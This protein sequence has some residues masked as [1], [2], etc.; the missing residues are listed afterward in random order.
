[1]AEVE[2]WG[3]TLGAHV[4]VDVRVDG[5]RP[6]KDARHAQL[7]DWLAGMLRKHGW[8]VLVEHS[9]NHFGDRGRIDVLAFHLIGRVLLVV[10]VKTRTDDAGDILG[11][12]DVKRR[13]A[14]ILARQ[15]QWPATSTV[16]MLLVLEHRTNR[17]RIADHA[18]IFAGFTLR[19]R[20]A[21]AWIRRPGAPEPSA[22]LLFAGGR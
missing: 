5:E 21:S 19:G 7:Q 20:A 6:M 14:P 22:I 16:P 12:L 2:R 3:V 11:R 10:E 9:F 8:S 13:V 17:R 15:Q 18:A 1:M 4:S